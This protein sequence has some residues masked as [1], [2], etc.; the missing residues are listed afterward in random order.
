MSSRFPALGALAFRAGR[1][2]GLS[3]LLHGL[4]RAGRCRTARVGK[5]GGPPDLGS[6]DPG[7]RTRIT[8]ENQL[9]AVANAG[10]A[11]LAKTRMAKSVFDGG[12]S[13]LSNR[14]DN[15]ARRCE[16]R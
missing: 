12:W 16:K 5:I 3:L 8:R 13:T 2:R 4:G 7:A 6:L 14:L 1:R 15:I 9:I 11:K 10:A